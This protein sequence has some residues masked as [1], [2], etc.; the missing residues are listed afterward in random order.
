MLNRGF[1]SIVILIFLSFRLLPL[2]NI[3]LSLIT[4]H[5]KLNSLSIFHFFLYSSSISVQLFCFTYSFCKHFSPFCPILL[6][7][8]PTRMTITVGPWFSNGGLIAANGTI[9]L[10]TTYRNASISNKYSTKDRSSTTPTPP[11]QTNGG[12]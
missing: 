3:V 1:T 10:Q 7:V 9:I 6:T 12:R 5:C 2:H 4:P 11:P 8:L